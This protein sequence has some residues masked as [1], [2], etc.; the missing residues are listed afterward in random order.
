[1]LITGKCKKGTKNFAPFLHPGFQFSHINYLLGALERDIYV[2]ANILLTHN[3][4]HPGIL[5]NLHDLGVD[6]GQDH[7]DA[8]L[9][10][11]AA[12]VGKVVHT[13]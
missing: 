10:T 6:S 8:H 2:T 3:L 11:H 12:H 7:L 4:V 9:R 1:M 13:C 5:Y